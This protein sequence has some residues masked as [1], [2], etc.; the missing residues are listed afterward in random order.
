[1]PLAGGWG[2]LMILG[3]GRGKLMTQAGGLVVEWMALVAGNAR[4]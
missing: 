4:S 2:K 1:M 3:S